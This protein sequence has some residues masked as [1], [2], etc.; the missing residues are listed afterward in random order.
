MKNSERLDS[1]DTG[2]KAPYARCQL[3]QGCALLPAPKIMAAYHLAEGEYD[4]A[5]PNYGW[6]GASDPAERDQLDWAK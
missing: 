6:S 2:H 5:A 4:P 3:R 1:D